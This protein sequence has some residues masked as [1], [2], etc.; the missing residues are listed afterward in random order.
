MRYVRR[1]E[2]PRK[3]E[4]PGLEYLSSEPV[5]IS[6]PFVDG[7]FSCY[8]RDDGLWWSEYVSTGR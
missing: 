4:M 5:I 7:P 3:V 1:T 6:P 8:T 2:A